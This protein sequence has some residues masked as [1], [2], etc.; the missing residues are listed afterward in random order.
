MLGSRVCR[1]R[2]PGIAAGIA[3]P[4]EDDDGGTGCASEQTVRGAA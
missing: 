4:G 2:V 3:A 1:G